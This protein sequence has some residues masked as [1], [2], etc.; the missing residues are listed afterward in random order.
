MLLHTQHEMRS[1]LNSDSFD[2]GNRCGGERE[3][4]G[5]GAGLIVSDFLDFVFGST[6]FLLKVG[7]TT[8]NMSF[9]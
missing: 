8:Q 2:P 5:S 9:M 6:I 7:N 4:M 1:S 3:L